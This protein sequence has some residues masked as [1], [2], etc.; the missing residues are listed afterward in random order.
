MRRSLLP[1]GLFTLVSL[2]FLFPKPFVLSMFSSFFSSQLKYHLLR[3]A[4]LITPHSG[5]GPLAALTVSRVQPHSLV[6]RGCVLFE[7]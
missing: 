3:K 1:L 2:E 4:S 7:A 5:L 6:S